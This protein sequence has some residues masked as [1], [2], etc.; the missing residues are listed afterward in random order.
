MLKNPEEDRP[1]RPWDVLFKKIDRVS[2]EV[3]DYRYS[4]CKSCDYLINGPSICKKCGC[5]MK[6][7]TTLPH[8]YC[9]INKWGTDKK[10]SNW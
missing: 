6:L 8:S 2:Q 3:A 5:L 4:I 9:P 7:K 1:A 10:H